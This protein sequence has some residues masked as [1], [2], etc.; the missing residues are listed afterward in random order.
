MTKNIN[1]L[2]R[3]CDAKIKEK[4]IIE[5]KLSAKAD[6]VD[7]EVQIFFAG[8][9]GTSRLKCVVGCN[10]YGCRNDEIDSG[11]TDNKCP[12]CGEIEGW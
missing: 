1:V 7:I 8:G 9:V 6:W 2:I 10:Y 3:E 4:E 11:S 12:V 5:E